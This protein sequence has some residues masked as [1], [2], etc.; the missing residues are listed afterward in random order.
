[1]AE[2][3][4]EPSQEQADLITPEEI[5]N[6]SPEDQKKLAYNIE[7]T[8]VMLSELTEEEVEK[9]QAMPWEKLDG[10]A[11]PDAPLT[12]EDKAAYREMWD[13]V[14]DGTTTMAEVLGYDED[15]IMK[16]YSVGAALSDQGRY[17]DALKIAEGLLFLMPKLVPGH[18]LKGEVL[19]KQGRLEEALEAYNAAVSADPTYIQSYFE[20]AKLFFR[21]ESGQYFLMDIQTIANLDPEAKTPFGKAAQKILEATAEELKKDGLSDEELEAIGDALDDAML[22]IDEDTIP[23]IDE[24]G[25]Q[26]IK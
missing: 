11:E 20:R 9:L 8:A 25:N 12:D 22:D 26:I 10:P 1:M 17:D 4:P 7:Q 16:T 14:Q 18:L 6:M 23:E 24:D 19:R 15:E 5:E 21:A 13:L 2:T 3:Q